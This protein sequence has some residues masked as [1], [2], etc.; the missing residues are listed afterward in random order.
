MTPLETEINYFNEHR[1]KFV[2]N[3]EGKYILIKGTE[4][5]GFFDTEDAAFNQGVI[6]FGTEPF[7]IQEVLSEDRKFDIPA[8]TL[9]LLYAH[10]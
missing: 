5:F 2:E 4:D 7:L 1:K 9:G 10:I 3:A 6:L 8:Y